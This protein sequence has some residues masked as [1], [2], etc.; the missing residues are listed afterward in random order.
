MS[1]VEWAEMANGLFARVG[2]LL[3]LVNPTQRHD[4]FFWEV[5]A[6]EPEDDVK[7]RAKTLAE[8]LRRCEE[9]ARQVAP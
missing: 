2:G 1:R 6:P 5:C 4:L 9:A 3:C 8:A 7:G